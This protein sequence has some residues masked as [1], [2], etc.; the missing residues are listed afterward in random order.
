MTIEGFVR[1]YKIA[2]EAVTRKANSETPEPLA[3]Y[4][5]QIGRDRLL[6]HE[7]EI[8]LGR[9]VRAGN[10]QVREKHVVKVPVPSA[11]TEAGP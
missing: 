3:K 1:R 11:P 6:T 9:R 10:K 2:R 7:E 4:L 8:E 5:A